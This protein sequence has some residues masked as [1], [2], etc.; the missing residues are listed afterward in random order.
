MSDLVSL[1]DQKVF[2]E[3]PVATTGDD[4]LITDLLEH[5]EDLLESDA[6]RTET[7]FKASAAAQT[8][9]HEGTGTRDL[10]LNYPISDITSISLG[11]DN[12]DFDETLDPDDPDEVVWGTGKRRISRVDGG[13]F[14]LP[15]RP[16]FITVVYDHQADLPEV[17]QL[18][19]K[20][21]V[22]QMYR[23]RG[24]E[25]ATKETIGGYAR[26]LS[27][28]VETDPFWQRAVA[29]TRRRVFA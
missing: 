5:A 25:D 10:Y 27:N 15:G 16:R 22:A 28:L 3:I 6:G 12:S 2:L 9:V 29:V 23:Q 26:D 4:D 8:E 24:S 14:G 13:R 17:A 18:A 20:R 7:P 21:V 19:I 11:L 1:A